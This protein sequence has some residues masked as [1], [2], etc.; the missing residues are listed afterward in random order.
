MK[1]ARPY[2]IQ[3][4]TSLYFVTFAVVYWIDVFSR[5]HYKDLV[6]DSLNFCASKKGLTIYAWCLM[7]NHIHLIISAKEGFQ[8]SDILRD[9]KK[10]TASQIIASIQEEPE[11]RREWMLWMFKRAGK[12]NARNTHHQFWQ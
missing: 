9:F 12:K 2:S 11:S 5:L 10:Y 8:L 6:V 7:S 4:D 3:N 1:S